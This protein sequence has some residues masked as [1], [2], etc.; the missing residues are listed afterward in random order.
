MALHFSIWPLPPPPFSFDHTHFGS[1]I[2]QTSKAAS[3][4]L[5]IL[6]PCSL[7]VCVCLSRVILL[8]FAARLHQRVLLRVCVSAVKRKTNSA[9]KLRALETTAHIGSR[10]AHT[11]TLVGD[12]LRKEKQVVKSLS[13]FDPP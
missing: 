3:V 6:M 13:S 1:P 5:L 4:L 10:Y 11:D 7:C 2:H 9:R 12:L 8:G